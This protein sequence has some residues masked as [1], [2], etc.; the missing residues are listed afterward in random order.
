MSDAKTVMKGTHILATASGGGVALIR[1]SDKK[2]VFYT[3]VGG[4]THSA[5]VLPDGNLVSASSTGSYLTFI[6][7]DTL[8]D[9][10]QVERKNIRLDFAHNV[11]WDAKSNLLWSAARQSVH[12]YQYNSGNLKQVDSIPMPGVE[13]HDLYPDPGTRDLWLTNTTDVYRFNIPQKAFLPAK[14]FT[15][16]EHIKS[17]SSGKGQATIVIKP[18]VSWWTNEVLD[19]TGARIF[20]MEGLKIYKARWL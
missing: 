9:P 14:D 13:G 11:V 5:E 4:N 17:V 2:T 19:K 10:E 6:R 20:Y 8:A 12:S 3:Y 16:H 18:K 1:L 15:F 7:V